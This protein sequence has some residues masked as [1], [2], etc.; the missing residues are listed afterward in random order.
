MSGG[1][2]KKGYLQV[3]LYKDKKK[4][5]FYIHRLVVEAFILKRKMRE[6]EFCDHINTIR[7]DNRVENLRVCSCKENNNNPLTLK[8]YSLAKS[9]SLILRGVND[10]SIYHFK[11]SCEA[12]SF[13]NYKKEETVGTYISQARKNGSNTINLNGEDFY[14]KQEL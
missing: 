7:T 4:K 6:D 12:S 9:K 3:Q 8:K 2:T 13:F 1:K 14:Y 11:S 10:A 5:L